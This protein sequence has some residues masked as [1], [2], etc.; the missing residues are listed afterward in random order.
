MKKFPLIAEC[1]DKQDG[2]FLVCFSDETKGV[3]VRSEYEGYKVGHV[4][5]NWQSCFDEVNWTI[6]VQPSEYPKKMYVGLNSGSETDA[7]RNKNKRT[8]V[9]HHEG[10]G[11]IDTEGNC[12]RYAVD[13]P[14]ESNN[15]EIHLGEVH[16]VSIEP[17]G[18]LRWY[19]NGKVRELQQLCNISGAFVWRNIE[20]VKE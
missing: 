7:L 16:G 2:A 5:Y 9:F 12:W 6:I 4:S 8:I 18:N 3:V 14:E 17:T 1:T 11:Y 13:I 20:T 15:Y 19:S 10:A